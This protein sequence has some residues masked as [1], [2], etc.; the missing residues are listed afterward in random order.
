M[1]FEELA[2]ELDDTYSMGLSPRVRGNPFSRK[3]SI[4]K[5]GSIPAWA[6]KPD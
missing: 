3:G 6:G 2:K 4:P 1:K 5:S